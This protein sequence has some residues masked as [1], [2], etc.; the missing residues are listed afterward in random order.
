[1]WW[2]GVMSVGCLQLYWKV[3]VKQAPLSMEL[4][5]QEYWSGML[6]PSPGDLLDPVIEPRSPALQADSLP[7]EPPGIEYWIKVF[8][9]IVTEK[10]NQ[11]ESSEKE[12]ALSHVMKSQGACFLASACFSP[13]LNST[14]S[15]LAPSAIGFLTWGY[16]ETIAF[17]T[18]LLI[19]SPAEQ[20]F[21][22]VSNGSPSTPLLW[23]SWVMSPSLSQPLGRKVLTALT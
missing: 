7:S 12:N 18:S 4:S 16:K 13:F 11:T 1:M 19:R 9:H 15:Q 2:V 3:K 23:L 17:S 20:S 5:R 22:I 6:F 21:G 10:P 8:P 14:F